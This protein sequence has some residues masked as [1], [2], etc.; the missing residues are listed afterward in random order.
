MLNDTL[1]AAYATLY[2]PQYGMGTVTDEQGHYQLDN[3]PVSTSVTLEYAFLGYKTEQVK[4]DLSQP[5]HR[6]AHDQRLTE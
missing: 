1:P 3:I 6:Y 4:V 2:L 5:N